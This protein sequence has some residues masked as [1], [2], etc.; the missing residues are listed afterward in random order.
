MRTEEKLLA[1]PNAQQ[2]AA[3][4]HSKQFEKICRWKVIFKS[5]ELEAM[6]IKLGRKA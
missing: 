3:K 4:G 2:A 5:L 1:D 6:K